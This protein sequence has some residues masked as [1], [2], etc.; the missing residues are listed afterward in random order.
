MLK[1]GVCFL[2]LFPVFSGFGRDRK[3]LLNLQVFLGKNRKSKERKD[4]VRLN[5]FE[6][7][8]FF[9]NWALKEC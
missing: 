7:D 3:S 9:Q 2:K 4:K 1:W 6:R 8:C 5:I